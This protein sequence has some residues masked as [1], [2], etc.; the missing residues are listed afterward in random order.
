MKTIKLIP[1]F[2]L[3]AFIANAQVP[4]TLTLKYCYQTAVKNYPL[5]RQKDLLIESSGLKVKN[6]NTSYYPRIDLNGQA[7][8]QS[9][10]TKLDIPK[11]SITMPAGVPQNFTPVIEWPQIKSPDKDQ[12]KITLDVSEIFY[13]GGITKA[14]KNLELAGLAADTQKVQV[15]LYQLKDRINQLYF[16]LLFF[17]EKEMLCEIIKN[18]L[19]T[20]VRAMQSGVKNGVAIEAGIN[21]LKAEIIKIDQQ[22]IEI[23]YGR[24]AGIKMLS[25][26]IG[27]DI[28]PTAAIQ[29]PDI[30]EAERIKSDRPEY[31]YFELQSKRIDASQKLIRKSNFPKLMGFGQAGYGRPGLNMLSTDFNDFYIIGAKLSWNVWDWKQKSR[32]IK[33][34]SLQ[35]DIIQTQLEVFDKNQKIMMQNEIAN[36]QKFEELVKKDSEIIGLCENITKSSSSRM[37]NGD[38][39]ATDYLSD[40]NC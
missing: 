17:Q 6:I 21:Q 39:T 2:I 35:K 18:D 5:L 34:L 19:N 23:K 24:I 38:I 29:V 20:K 28:K 16:S 32:E 13:D 3:L 10:V 22:L 8:Y 36:S 1:V 37:I 7:T 14:Q 15:D 33:M 40:L 25:E 4:D 12:Y 11:P 27:T 26:L 9:D 31:K 30:K